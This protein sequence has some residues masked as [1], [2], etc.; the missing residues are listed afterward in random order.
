MPIG[1][2]TSQIFSNIYLNELDRFVKHVLGV[3]AYLRY[4]DDFLIFAD[5]PKKLAE[6]R[7]KV[8]DFLAVNLRLTINP[9]N[10]VALKAQ[11]GLKFLGVQLWPQGRRLTKRNRKRVKKRLTASNLSSYYGV[12]SKHQKAARMKEFYWQTME[13][14]VDP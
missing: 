6:L 14:V 10:D 12:L 4:G 11:H 1:N 2:L 13:E 3:R 7:S 9:K 8:I 5:H